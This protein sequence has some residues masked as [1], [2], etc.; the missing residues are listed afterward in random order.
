MNRPFRD[1][2]PSARIS[3]AAISA[4]QTELVPRQFDFHAA[5][6][7]V[8][9]QAWTIALTSLAV[10]ALT[11]LLLTQLQHRYTAT[12]LLI[13]D[14]RDSQLVGFESAT[15]GLSANSGVDTE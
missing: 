14:A 10:V 8:R 3:T 5:L 6:G 11:V 12:A 15:D 4:V 9:R 7:L 2:A 13:V 1:P